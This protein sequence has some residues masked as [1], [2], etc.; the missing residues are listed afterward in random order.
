[1]SR[2]RTPIWGIVSAVLTLGT[3]L[4]SVLATLIL[5][6][7]LKGP[8]P[9]SVTTRVPGFVY[10]SATV[11][12]V[13]V[14]VGIG[15]ATVALTRRV[16]AGRRDRAGGLAYPLGQPFPFWGIIAVTLAP[17]TPVVGAVSVILAQALAP[18]PETLS[19][20][21]MSRVS[22]VAVIVSLCLIVAGAM[23][24]VTSLLKREHP[25][26]LPVLGMVANAVLIG[27]FWHFQFD[28]VGFDQDTWAP[29]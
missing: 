21:D 18:A 20:H 27:L 24:A 8:G 26:L 4:S 10:A 7:F 6:A 3:L 19:M 17:L 5:D 11:M 1:M 12:K 23:A 13:C 29:R 25:V 16:F 22:R 9:A 2:V 15:A 14:V 28:A